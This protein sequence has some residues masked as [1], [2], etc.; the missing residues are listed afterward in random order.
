MISELCGRWVMVSD[1][2]T[3]S[4]QCEGVEAPQTSSSRSERNTPQ[5]AVQRVLQNILS[6]GMNGS[7]WHC[8]NALRC[9]SFEYGAVCILQETFRIC[10]MS[11]TKST[12]DNIRRSA[13]P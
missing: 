4:N 10:F 6:Y 11:F 9:T 12:R 13:G 8:E 2:E 5:R 1:A 7:C 3:F